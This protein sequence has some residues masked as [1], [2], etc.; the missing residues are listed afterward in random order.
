MCKVSGHAKDAFGLVFLALAL[1]SPGLRLPT[2]SAED[3]AAAPVAPGDVGVALLSDPTRTSVSPGDTTALRFV[4]RRGVDSASVLD[5]F[6]TSSHHK[7]QR[8]QQRT[9]V[10]G[11]PSAS[12]AGVVR[13]RE[14]RSHNVYRRTQGRCA[15]QQQV[16]QLQTRERGPLSN[17]QCSQHLRK[18]HFRDSEHQQTHAH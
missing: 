5:A 17:H 13:A 18:K 2:A 14:S 7:Q 1:P 3:P 6:C 10:P 15:P 12:R 9:Y 11:W 8:M 4:L 16:K